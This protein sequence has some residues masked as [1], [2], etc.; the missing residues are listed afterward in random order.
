MKTVQIDGEDGVETF[1]NAPLT[2]D[3][4]SVG[5]NLKTSTGEEVKMTF[6]ENAGSGKGKSFQPQIKSF[7]TA[8]QQ[9]Q[10]RSAIQD[11]QIILVVGQTGSGRTQMLYAIADEVAARF[12]AERVAVLCD[13]AERLGDEPANLTSYAGSR[14]VTT[15]I[16]QSNTSLFVDELRGNEAS[17]LLDAWCK[18]CFG[19]AAVHGDSVE[20][21]LLRLKSLAGASF[22]QAVSE[23]IHLVVLMERTA[24]G[25]CVTEIRRLSA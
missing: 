2:G 24:E 7:A 17:S 23:N 3:L 10:I 18:G 12:P 5:S 19:G 11:R 9:D 20:Q 1:E 6:A 21:G 25:P 16:R 15:E 22:D 8:H 4:V 13:L 14:D